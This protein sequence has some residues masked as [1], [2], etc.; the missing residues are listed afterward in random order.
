MKIMYEV[1]RGQ[2]PHLAAYYDIEGLGAISFGKYIKL[3]KSTWDGN[4]A[5][6]PTFAQIAEQLGDL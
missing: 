5:S 3:L 6:R 2:R 1:E 4:P